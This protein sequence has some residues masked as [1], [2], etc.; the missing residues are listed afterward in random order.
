MA[1]IGRARRLRKRET[2]AEKLMWHW[3]RARR[4]NRYKFRRQ[5]PLDDHILD[6][7]CEAAELSIEVDGSRHGFL[8]QHKH[9]V[10]REAF[11]KSRGIKTR[12]FWNSSLRR[13]ARNIR[14]TIVEEPQKRAPLPLPDYTKPMIADET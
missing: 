4:F 13:D 7:F 9:D 3:L 10:E 11:L 2:W 12:R 8:D 5:H 1:D 6:L 14:D